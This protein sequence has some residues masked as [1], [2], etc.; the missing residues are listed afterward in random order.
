V[1][2][3]LFGA[4]ARFRTAVR[5]DRLAHVANEIEAMTKQ[6]L[7]LNDFLRGLL[8]ALAARG[9]KSVLANQ[10]DVH[11]AFYRVVRDIQTRPTRPLQVDLIDFD[12][13]PLYGLSGWLDRALTNAQRDLL[14]SFPNP[15]YERLEIRY[16]PDEGR[17]ILAALG[18]QDEFLALADGFAADLRTPQAQV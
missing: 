4:K 5:R 9:N 12:Y 8:A 18:N 14:I 3:T 7:N 11:R 13:D 10:F 17:Q 6:M 16:E 15:S 2:W 1:L